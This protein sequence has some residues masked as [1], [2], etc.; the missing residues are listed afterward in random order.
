MNC[1][2]DFKG[3]KKSHP[4]DPENIKAGVFLL[5]NTIEKLSQVDLMIY[6][7]I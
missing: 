6:Q 3:S 5:K 2:I 1:Q 4:K 7:N